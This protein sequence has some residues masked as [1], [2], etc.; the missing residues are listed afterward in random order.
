M[1]PLGDIQNSIF[2]NNHG[3]TEKLYNY[4][5]WNSA[6]VCRILGNFVRNTDVTDE[7]KTEF[8]VDGISWAPYLWAEHIIPQISRQILSFSCTVI[9]FAMHIPWCNCTV[10]FKTMVLLTDFY[11]CS[12]FIV[13]WI[14]SV[15][16]VFYRQYPIYE[17]LHVA[18]QWWDFL[19]LFYLVYVRF[20]W[21]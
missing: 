12:N 1:C 14:A 3:I 2:G 9:S 7:Q 20:F 21:K 16:C 11:P 13:F 6:K 10:V 4:A 18:D 17:I 19:K 5:I 8:H 15:N